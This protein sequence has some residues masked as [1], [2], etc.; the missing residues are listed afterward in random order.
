MTASRI[1]RPL[2]A[3]SAIAIA[4]A[5][6][7]KAPNHVDAVVRVDPIAGIRLEVAGS[8]RT[9]L[10]DESAAEIGAYDPGG[11]LLFVTNASANTVDV[12][13]IIN[14]RKPQLKFSIDL[15]RYGAGIN[16]VAVHDG[17]VAVAVQAEPKQDPGS[18]VLFDRHAVSWT[19]TP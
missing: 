15:A 18:V 12:L 8:Y 16:S 6:H 19:S 3:A 11:R 9:G 14:V 7:A 5:A 4:I 2:A 1:L 10:F 13:S 17:L